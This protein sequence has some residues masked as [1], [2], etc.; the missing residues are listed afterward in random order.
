MVKFFKSTDFISPELKNV[1]TQRS[2]RED[3]SDEAIGFVQIKRQPEFNLCYVK[4]KITPE[5]RVNA[6]PYSVL[7]IIN[8]KDSEII[9]AVCE[10]C[11]A[12][13]GGCKHAVAFVTWL[14]RHAMEP[15]VTETKCYWLK[16]KLSAAA[17]RIVKTNDIAEQVAG[18]ISAAK[19]EA[20]FNQICQTLNVESL[21]RKH[22]DGHQTIK[23]SMFHLINDFKVSGLTEPD[24]FIEFASTFLKQQDLKLWAEETKGQAASPLWHTLRFGRICASKLYE[25]AHCTTDDGT[26]VSTILGATKF[27]PSAAMKRGTALEERIL[28]TVQHIYDI[29]PEKMGLVVKAEEPVFGA[30]PDGVTENFVIEVKAPSSEKTFRTYFTPNMESPAPKYM[31][32]VQLQMYLLGQERAIFA[33]A[34]PNYE[35]TYEVVSIIVEFDLA[36]ITDLLQR[37]R[38]FWKKSIFPKLMSA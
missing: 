14:H 33:V 37:A 34:K 12:C 25:A 7:C 5:H 19:K 20:F 1:K 26:L 11:A 9:K 35:E 6:K 29:K 15:S 10:D 4:A 18:N 16:S 27:K 28:Q 22:I 3:Y 23:K 24:E 31:A 36:L 21:V 30:S 8:E 38:D 13:Q 17:S 2:A 32:Q